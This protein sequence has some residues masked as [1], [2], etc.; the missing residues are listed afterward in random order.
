MKPKVLIEMDT[1]EEVAPTLKA[2]AHPL[3]LRI[4]D[5]LEEG[6]LTVMEKF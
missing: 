2:V 4:L 1:L 5:V 3:R 6:G